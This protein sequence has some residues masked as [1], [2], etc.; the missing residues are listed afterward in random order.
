MNHSATN[1]PARMIALPAPTPPDLRVRFRRSVMPA[2]FV[3]TTPALWPA[4]PCG[5]I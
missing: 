5:P 1:R 4:S 2:A 3:L